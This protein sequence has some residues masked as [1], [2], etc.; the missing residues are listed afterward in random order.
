MLI[1]IFLTMTLE[2]KPDKMTSFYSTVRGM[3][4]SVVFG[5]KR[6]VLL[7]K[8]IQKRSSITKNIINF[9]KKDERK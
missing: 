2:T 3:R 1:H 7:V 6:C 9:C 5:I 4:L 8:L